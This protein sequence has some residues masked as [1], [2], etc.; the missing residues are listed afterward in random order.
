[1]VMWIM[2]AICGELTELDRDRGTGH[3]RILGGEYHRV[4]C[5]F[6]AKLSKVALQVFAGGLHQFLGNHVSDGD[7]ECF[8]VWEVVGISS[9]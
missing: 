2:D 7:D 5:F 3:I 9:T 1:M 4:P 8:D 6:G